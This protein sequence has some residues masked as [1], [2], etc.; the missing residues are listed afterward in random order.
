M[1]NPEAT[2]TPPRIKPRVK[3]APKVRQVYWC[4]FPQD[5]QLPEMW[6]VRPVLIIGKKATLYGRITALPLSSKSQPDNP[7]AYRIVSPIDGKDTWVICDYL[8]SLAVSRLSPPDRVIPRVDEDD[9]NKIIE[10][11][12]SLLPTPR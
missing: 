5:A 10:L 3:S 11:A 12:Y 9:F 6:K 1:N 7:Y 2:E 4:E 8:I